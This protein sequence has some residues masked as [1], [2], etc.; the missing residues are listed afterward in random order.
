MKDKILSY[1]KSNKHHWWTV[2]ILPGLYAITYLYSNNYTLVNSWTQLSY[3]V[4]TMVIAPS[5]LIILIGFLLKG[6]SER[7]K[8]TFYSSSLIII[9]A[10]SLSL[11]V[12]LGWRWK[13]LLMVAIVAILASWFLGKHYKKGVLILSTMC[14]LGVLQLIFYL[15]TSLFIYDNWVKESPLVTIE[16][17]IKPNIYYIQPDG[18][19]NKLSLENDNYNFDNEIFYSNMILK[20]FNFS[21]QYHSNYPSTLTSNATLFTGQHH[22]Y[23]KEK[24]KN[25][26]FNARQ[27][28]MGKNPVL[29]TFKNNGYQTTAI[30]QHRYLLLNHPEIYYDRINIE[31]SELSI[32]PDYKLDKDYFNDLK[33]AINTADNNPQFYFIEILEPGHI[34]GLKT[35]DTS[36]KK[37]RDLYIDN[38]KRINTTLQSIVEYISTTDPEGIII[39]AADHGGFVGYDYTGESYSNLTEDASLHQAIYGALLAIKAPNEFAPPYQENVKSS[40]GL[41]PALFSYLANDTARINKLDNSSYQLIKRGGTQRVFID[42]MMKMEILSQRKYNR[43]LTLLLLILIL[44]GVITQA[45]SCVCYQNHFLNDYKEADFIAQVTVT[46]V[47]SD[48]RIENEDLIEFDTAIV[49]K[50]A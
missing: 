26:L 27:I 49:F 22:L 43:L 12:Y 21:H 28:I 38:L 25:E 3:L 9:T 20:G 24:F 47:D 41:F 10:I 16:F 33:H 6:K 7:I 42:I 37:E 29:E 14:F 46:S 31:E 8:N 39:M 2:G 5:A 13:A 44:T 17:Q 35:K 48:Y 19:A 18:Y 23:G 1:L 50:G 40:I 4:L 15:F 32:L 36:A 11:V 34:T 45:Q 30:L